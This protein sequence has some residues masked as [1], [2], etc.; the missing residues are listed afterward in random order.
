MRRIRGKLHDLYIE[1]K[2]YPEKSRRRKKIW[3]EI[4]YVEHVL[5]HETDKL[6]DRISNLTVLRDKLQA[7]GESYDEIQDTIDYYEALIADMS[8]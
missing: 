2:K 6:Y 4:I 1:M 7:V 3:E 8:L 5:E